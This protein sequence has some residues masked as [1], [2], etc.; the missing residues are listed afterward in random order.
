MLCR[1]R[2]ARGRETAL[3][4]ADESLL[5]CELSRVVQETGQPGYCLENRG[6]S[7][8]PCS[9]QDYLFAGRRPDAGADR[10]GRGATGQPYTM[11]SEVDRWVRTRMA[12]RSHGQAQVERPGEWEPVF[13]WPGGH[14]V[15]GR[16]KV[17]RA[18]SRGISNSAIR[19]T[20]RVG[21]AR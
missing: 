17:K 11:V 16:H 6:V 18:N 9:S 20:P 7:R 8:S 5:R 10:S 13:Y 2:R 15:A 1:A 12:E 21:L 19:P 4:I 14:G 3:K